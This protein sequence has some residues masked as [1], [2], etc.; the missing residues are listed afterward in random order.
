MEPIS[1]STL[2]Y[3]SVTTLK[4]FV[5]VLAFLFVLTKCGG[6]DNNIIAPKHDNSQYFA[7][8]KSDSLK[9]AKLEEKQ[10]EDSLKTIASKQPEDSIKIVAD[11]YTKLYKNSSKKVR[12]LL[13]MGICDTVEITIAL[14][15]CDSTIKSKDELLAQKDTTY[16]RVNEE[17]NTVKEQ[18]SITKGMVVTAKTIIKN[19]SE[20]YKTLE[21]TSKKE[22]RKQKIKTIGV[23]IVSALAEALTIFALK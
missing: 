9:I 23:I 1:I 16:N 13:A 18:L 15:N 21:K 17:L 4:V 10:K 2:K 5:L 6:C 3:I 22:L 20:D 19:Q 14:N 12:E 8:I 7:K 11:K